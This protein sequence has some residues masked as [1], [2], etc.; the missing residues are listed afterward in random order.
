VKNRNIVT[1]LVEIYQEA[2]MKLFRQA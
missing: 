1:S 2:N